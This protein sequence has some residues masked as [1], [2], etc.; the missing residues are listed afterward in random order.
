MTTVIIITAVM[1]ACGA[2]IAFSLAA[3]A[4]YYF[5]AVGGQPMQVLIQRMVGGVNSFA[6]LALPLFILAGNLM[7]RGGVAGKIMNFCHKLVSHLTGG[8][9]IVTILSSIFFGAI[10]GSGVAG[11]AA[12]SKMV[13]S[14]MEKRGYSKAFTAALLSGAGVLGMIIPPSV[15][16]VV[17]GVA[18]NVSITGLLLGG[19][20]PGILTGGALIVLSLMVCKKRGYDLHEGRRS[21]VGELWSAF[22]EAFLS[23]LSPVIILGG[24]LGGVVTPT[25][26]A[27]IAVVYA[28]FLGMFVYHKITWR[29]LPKILSDSVSSSAVIMFIMAVSS[30]FSWILAKENV[31]TTLAGFFLS[32][33]QNKYV[34]MLLINLLLL[35]L[36]CF[37]DAG[38]II[39]IL[40]PIL[41][42]I[43]SRYG[44]NP[45]H[46]GVM[47]VLN[48]A[49][50]GVTPP[51]GVTLITSSRI[52][53][54][55]VS[56][57]L[58]DA[59]YVVI[60]MVAALLLVMCIP[61]IVLLIPRLG[62][63]R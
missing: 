1:L 36:G 49:I 28:W 42:P 24:I 35:M 3:A 22:K 15:S 2:P 39:M 9:S 33:T 23:L 62:G 7:D 47:F 5:V 6:L 50:G 41:V 14:N 20:L 55:N 58:R 27:V 8:M 46:F 30:A 45:V 40:A 25:E 43:A 11:T 48:L 44:I 31:A 32:I 16:M 54:V 17:F 13:G 26:A 18:G 61:D 34:L 12:V 52:I 38:G 29:E 51:L 60:A 37:M 4:I 59:L 63:V 21:S 57:T 56:D 53:G 19:I 10:T